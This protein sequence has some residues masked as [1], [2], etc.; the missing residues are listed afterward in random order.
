MKDVFGNA[1][2]LTLAG[3]SHGKAIIA[4]LSGFPAGFSV[5]EAEISRVLSRRKP[6]ET[7]STERREADAF[8]IL[9]GV[10]NGKTTGA[11][12]TFLIPNGDLDDAPYE[13]QG[14]KLRPGH[15]DY[16]AFVKSFGNNDP[17][18]GGRS[19]GRLTVGLVAAG[20][21]ALSALRQKGIEIKTHIASCAGIAD[22]DFSDYEADFS[23][24]NEK[25]LAV[26]SEEAAEKMKD[27]VKAAAEDG[28]SV[29]G[30]L[31]TVITGV[32][33]GL[34]E[35][36]FDSVESLISHLLFSIPAVKGV[37]FGDGFA[38]CDRRGSATND[39][40][41]IKNGKIVTKYNHNGGINGGI[42]NG[43]PILFKTAVK[44]TPSVAKE[45]ETVDLETMTETTL[46][47]SGRHD[48]AIVLRAPVIVDAA[49]ALVLCDLFSQRFGENWL[50]EGKQWN[51]V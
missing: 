25:Q 16:T 41:Y 43:M 29:G 13:A 2:S 26:L 20:A 37:E 28:D 3:E 30:V 12:I 31:E 6:T 24:L 40:F 47:V 4:V 34:G 10:Y 32:P 38:L 22:R 1:V 39:P 35:P 36:W 8:E 9:S 44:P 5:D 21:L 14:K 51:T 15:A 19:S 11:P 17:R 48:A 18:G 27:A 45:Q 49:A 23:I 7:G 42:T 46:S 33:A 50:T